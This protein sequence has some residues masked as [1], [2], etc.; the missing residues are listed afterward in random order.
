MAG[1]R[2]DVRLDRE[3]RRK[4]SELAAERKTAVSELVR[5]II[6]EA[7]EDSLQARRLRAAGEPRSMKGASQWRP[8]TT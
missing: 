7:Y 2:L 6:D 3:G 8:P 5:Q 4:L 1:D